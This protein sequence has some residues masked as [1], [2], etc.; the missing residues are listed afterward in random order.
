[1][2]GLSTRKIERLVDIKVVAYLI[3]VLVERMARLDARFI[4]LLKEQVNTLLKLNL[5]Y[6]GKFHYAIMKTKTELKSL[7][8]GM[9]MIGAVRKKMA[10]M[11]HGCVGLV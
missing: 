10:H 1:M 11:I 3:I 4:S 8:H 7:M 9:Q 2:V 6:V 5:V